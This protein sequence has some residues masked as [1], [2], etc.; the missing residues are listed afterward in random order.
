MGV[1]WKGKGRVMEG[2]KLTKSI[3]FK[4]PLEGMGNTSRNPFEH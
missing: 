1:A 2:D 3:L 4:K